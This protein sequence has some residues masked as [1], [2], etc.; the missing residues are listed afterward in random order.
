MTVNAKTDK[1]IPEG[2]VLAPEAIVAPFGEVIL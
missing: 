1:P 2:I